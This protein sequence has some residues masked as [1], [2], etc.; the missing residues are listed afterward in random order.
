MSER[1]RIRITNYH[2]KVFYRLIDC[3]VILCALYIAIK[4]NAH[5]VTLGYI[6]AGLLGVIIYSFIAESLDIYSHWRTAKLRSLALY[7]SFVGSLPLV[8]SRYSATFQK[9]AQTFPV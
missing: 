3:L 1:G 4:A 9:L 5:I 2:G 6:S 8:D 7:T